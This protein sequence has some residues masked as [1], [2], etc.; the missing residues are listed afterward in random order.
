MDIMKI[1]MQMIQ[2]F[3]LM[4]VGYGLYHAKIFDEVLNKK[5]TSF[6]LN[7]TMPSM[8]IASVLSQ[9]KTQGLSQIAIVFIIGIL[10][11]I[12]LPVVGYVMAKIMKTPDDQIGLYIFM[13]VFSNVG[14]MGYPVMNAIYGE[15]SV[16][17][18]SIFNMLF[19]IFLYT[20]GRPLM[21]FGGHDK[22]KLNL[23]TFMTPGILASAFAI[24]CYFT[25]F[26]LPDVMI[27]TLDMIGDMTTPIAMLIIGSTLATM[28]LKEVFNEKR[29]YL[30]TLIKQIIFPILMYPLLNMFINDPLIL[31]VTL[32]M[33]SMPVGNSAVLFANEYGGNASIA[34]K[35]IFMTTL[36]SVLTIPL[37]VDLFLA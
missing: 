1:L 20:I 18:T 12:L 15:Q 22:V 3:S 7:V 28:P 30:F 24:I 6:L 9:Q 4:A 19:N 2:L 37:I 33:L 13:N 36:L 27:S 26:S 23:K 8:I 31:G 14:F 21:T 35:N 17:Y 11:Y 29:V 32:I 34:A 5:L 25:G 16:L 10:T